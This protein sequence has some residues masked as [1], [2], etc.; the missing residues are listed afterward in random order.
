MLVTAI[1][2]AALLLCLGLYISSH[3][4]ALSVQRVTVKKHDDA[5][6]RS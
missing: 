5:N 3:N 1:T 6:R 2:T 4:N